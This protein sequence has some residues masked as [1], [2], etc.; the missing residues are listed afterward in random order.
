MIGVLSGPRIFIVGGS[1]PSMNFH[2]SSA[3]FPR[4]IYSKYHCECCYVVNPILH[5]LSSRSFWFN[6]IYVHC[7]NNH[8]DFTVNDCNCMTVPN[9]KSGQKSCYDIKEPRPLR[10]IWVVLLAHSTSSNECWNERPNEVYYLINLLKCVGLGILSIQFPN[11]CAGQVVTAQYLYLACPF[12]HGIPPTGA[13][14]RIQ[15]KIF[16]GM[17]RIPK[18]LDISHEDLCNGMRNSLTNHIIKNVNISILIR[19]E[20]K[21]LRT[22]KSI[23][24]HHQCLRLETISRLI[25]STKLFEQKFVINV[26]MLKFNSASKSKSGK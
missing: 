18:A 16:I 25:N 19:N 21:H 13:P 7:L 4:E 17:L 3:D 12:Q 5:T 11:K 23:K 15:L 2:C 8:F 6:V 22:T 9:I 1:F 26:S 14:I 24:Y 20:Q 10:R